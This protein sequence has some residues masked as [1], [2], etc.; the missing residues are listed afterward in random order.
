VVSPSNHELVVP[1][2]CVL[3]APQIDTNPV[4]FYRKFLF[5]LKA[6]YFSCF[7]KKS[8]QKKAT[9]TIVLILRC[10]EKSGTEKTRFAQTVFRSDRFF[11]ALLGDNQRGPVGRMFDRFAMRTTRAEVRGS[12]LRFA[13][14]SGRMRRRSIYLIGASVPQIAFHFQAL[15]YLNQWLRKERA[16]VCDLAKPDQVT[17]LTAL[18]KAAATF[19]VARNL[20]DEHRVGEG[21]HKYEPVL[22]AIDRLG[23]EKFEGENLVAAVQF[24]EREISKSFGERNV[25]SLTTKMLWLKFQSPIIIYDGNA[26]RALKLK[27]KPNDLASFY[28]RWRDEYRLHTA[29]IDEACEALPLAHTYCY[30]QQFTQQEIRNLASEQWFKERVFD[31]HLWRAGEKAP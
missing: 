24:V 6:S 11:P 30:D 27:A 2:G 22:A 5:R 12:G 13:K 8:N 21:E 28:G 18:K 9:P 7:A 15:H 20:R 1:V 25:L 26:V 4:G 3:N 31:I 10:S 29:Q 19:R 16:Y 23:R 14:S 17:R